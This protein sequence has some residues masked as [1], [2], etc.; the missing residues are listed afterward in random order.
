M[1]YSVSVR[2]MFLFS[3]IL[4][5]AHGFNVNEIRRVLE[6]VSTNRVE[7]DDDISHLND[8]LIRANITGY[9]GYEK[10]IRSVLH[11]PFLY[12]F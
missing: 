6:F 9:E 10:L 11:M 12:F 1:L 5:R 8:L 3:Y 7:E 4:Y 2:L